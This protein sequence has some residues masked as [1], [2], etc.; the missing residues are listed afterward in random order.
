[1]GFLAS[2]KYETIEDLF[3]HELRDLYDAEHQLL[4]ALPKMAEAASS[5]QLRATLESHSLDTRGHVR[6]LEEV[7]AALHQEPGRDSCPAMKGLIKESSEAIDAAGSD[8]VRDAA[9]IAVSNRVEHYEIAGYGTLRSL[10][11][12][13]GRPDLADLL[14]STLPQ[15]KAASAKLTGLAKQR[16]NP[17]A[18]R[19]SRRY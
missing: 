15:E 3:H 10:A 8:R 18:A 7:F 11:Q 5:P 1:M 9:L 14:K 12:E 16:V 19:Q 2:L 17:D 4:D 6:R 13:I